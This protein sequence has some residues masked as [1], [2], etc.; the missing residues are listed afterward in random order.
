MAL[1][2]KQ[3]ILAAQDLATETVAVPEWG[4]EVVVAT[5]SRADYDAYEDS[6]SKR[7]GR[8]VESNLQN[9]TARLC[10]LCVVDAAGKRLF[11][12]ADVAALGAKSSAALQRVYDVALRL[13]RPADEGDGKNSGT[14]P[15]GSSS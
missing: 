11:D 14:G 4:G 2:T 1:L 8:K 13:N 6:L 7:V 12:E 9:F 3:Q 10:A 5:L 15:G